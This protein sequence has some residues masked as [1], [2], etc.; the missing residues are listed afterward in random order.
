MFMLHK[1]LWAQG[2]W[3]WPVAGALVHKGVNPGQ[4][5]HTENL[6]IIQAQVTSSHQTTVNS[7]ST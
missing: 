2:N 4:S 1:E 3:L 6:S 5:S 7:T